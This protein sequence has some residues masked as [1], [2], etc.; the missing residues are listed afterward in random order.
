MTSQETLAIQLSNYK[1]GYKNRVPI[2]QSE[3]MENAMNNL[4]ASGIERQAKK[5]GDVAPNIILLDAIGNPVSLLT[6]W[7]RGPLVVIFY[8][9]G[10]VSLLQFAASCVAKAFE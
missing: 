8:R 4:K 6:L 7:E 1:A 5:Q 9:G 10:L 3:M 2:A